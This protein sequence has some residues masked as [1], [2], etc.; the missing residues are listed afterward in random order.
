MH[1]SLDYVAY[2][3]YRAEKL[4]KTDVIKT[5]FDFDIRAA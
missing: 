3:A 4:V 5:S 1:R 2:I